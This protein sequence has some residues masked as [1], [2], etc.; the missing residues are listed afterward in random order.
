[1]GSVGSLVNGQPLPCICPYF[2]E[3]NEADEFSDNP[4]AS[5]VIGQIQTLGFFLLTV[6]VWLPGVHLA[7]WSPGLRRIQKP[8]LGSVGKALGWIS[9]VCPGCGQGSSSLPAGLHPT[10]P[11]LMDTFLPS[12]LEV[13]LISHWSWSLGASKRGPRHPLRTRAG[14]STRHPSWCLL[15]KPLCA[16]GF[17]L[18]HS[19]ED[20]AGLTALPE[21][22]FRSRS[23]LAEKD[24]LGSE[25]EEGHLESIA[26]FSKSQMKCK[27]QWPLAPKP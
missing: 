7:A 16:L 9:N 14:V 25:H 22:I 1:M 6:S 3:Q 12:Q 23:V 5:W 13:H 11:E 8:C 17:S 27:L 18:S 20:A 4:E 15:H 19:R 24:P 2:R 26:A 21:S 10:G